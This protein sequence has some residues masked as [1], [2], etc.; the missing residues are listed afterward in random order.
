MRLLRSV[1]ILWLVYY[2]NAF[3]SHR[4]HISTILPTASSNNAP[5]AFDEAPT[6]TS[7]FR[8]MHQISDD[9]DDSESCV[10]NE[11]SLAAPRNHRRG[12][13]RKQLVYKIKMSLA[14]LSPIAMVSS[15]V[16]LVANPQK[17]NAGAPVMAMPKMKT[18]DPSQ[19]AFDRHERTLMERLRKNFLTFSQGRGKSKKKKGQPHVINLRKSMQNLKRQRPRRLRK[20]L[21]SLNAT[22]LM[23]A[24]THSRISKGDVRSSS[25]NEE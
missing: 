22:Y 9:L 12:Q 25:T 11:E 17:A 4:I 24:L 8:T 20:D 1:V 3:Q 13:F 18:Q 16:A 2:T 19:V 15:S 5:H 6:C 7:I 23:M 10:E 21:L 14:F